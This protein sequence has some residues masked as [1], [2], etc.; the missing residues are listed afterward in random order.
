MYSLGFGTIDIRYGYSP[1]SKSNIII[2][3]YPVFFFIYEYDM[4][5]DIIGSIVSAISFS[6]EFLL[7]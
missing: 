5:L 7:V 3:L 1:N 6:V 4:F 2:G